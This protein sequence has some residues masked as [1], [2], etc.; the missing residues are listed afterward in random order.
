MIANFKGCG[1]SRSTRKLV[2]TFILIK[3]IKKYFFDKSKNNYKDENIYTNIIWQ[4]TLELWDWKK[5]KGHI[6][7]ITIKENG[8]YDF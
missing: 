2:W 3:K 6:Y 1:I 8:I 4:K 7:G 5:V